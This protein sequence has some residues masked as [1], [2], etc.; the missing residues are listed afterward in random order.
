MQRV[1]D[2][3]LD[4]F[5]QRVVFYPQGEARANPREHSVAL[6]VDTL[7]E[8]VSDAEIESV[9]GYVD[10]LD[11]VELAIRYLRQ[12]LCLEGPIAGAAV[13]HHDEVFS[14]WRRLITEGTL[15]PPFHVT[16]VDAHGDSGKGTRSGGRWGLRRIPVFCRESVMSGF[17]KREF[18]PA[19][20]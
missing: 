6:G 5:V 10:D 11:G 8:I 13:R 14:L 16:H 1:L 9:N 12:R 2:L 18:R 20:L 3:D 7:L 19:G 17:C 15:V 4:F